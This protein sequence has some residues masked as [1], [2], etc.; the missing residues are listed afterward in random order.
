MILQ[1]IEAVIVIAAVVLVARFSDTLVKMMKTLI[2]FFFIDLPIAGMITL[3]FG[4]DVFVSFS[5]VY[6]AL[7]LGKMWQMHKASQQSDISI[8]MGNI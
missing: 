6:I 7:V 1:I 2:V 4:L 8:D 3:L 5:I